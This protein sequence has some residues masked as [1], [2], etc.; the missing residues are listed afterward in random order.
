MGASEE[1]SDAPQH[2]CPVV[3]NSPGE[4][5]LYNI[6]WRD[7]QEFREV[8]DHLSSSQQEEVFKL[9]SEIKQS[10]L[11]T[12]SMVSRL[13]PCSLNPVWEVSSH[14]FC[15]TF[16]TDFRQFKVQILSLVVD[17]LSF[18]ESLNRSLRRD[19]FLEEILSGL[20]KYE[21]VPFLQWERPDDLVQGLIL[22]A[23][24]CSTAK[25]LGKTSLLK[26]YQDSERQAQFLSATLEALGLIVR[27]K[28]NRKHYYE[29][30]NAGR[31]ITSLDDVNLQKNLL[32]KQLQ[33]HPQVGFWLQEIKNKNPCDLFLIQEKL[34]KDFSY[35]LSKITFKRRAESLYY[36]IKWLAGRDLLSMISTVDHDGFSSVQLH[37]DLASAIQES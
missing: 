30:T 11:V 26:D 36:I 10:G 21:E 33:L 4:L 37:L 35:Q 17:H 23:K 32:H 34:E 28:K 3:I 19:S 18:I 12:A 29:L 2:D 22:I 24:G 25:D 27:Q 8:F 7:K 13:T 14:G 31:E 20:N 16:V 15:L 6:I 9:L 1:N 5:T